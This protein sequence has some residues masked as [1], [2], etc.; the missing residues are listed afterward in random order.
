MNFDCDAVYIGETKQYAKNRFSQHKRNTENSPKS[1]A[2]SQHCHNF[3]H[4]FDLE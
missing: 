1:T 2:L 4:S 3:R